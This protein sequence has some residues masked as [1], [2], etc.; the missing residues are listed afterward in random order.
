MHV[1][2]I[3]T[4]TSLSIRWTSGD[5]LWTVAKR[6]NLGNRILESAEIECSAEVGAEIDQAHAVIIAERMDAVFV[7]PE[8]FERAKVSYDH[9]DDGSPVWIGDEI[10][11]RIWIVRAPEPGDRKK[12]TTM[13]LGYST[14]N[15]NQLVYDE[16]I[17]ISY[18][19]W[20]CPACGASF[21]GGGKAMHEKGCS[22]TGYDGLEYHFGPKQVEQVK[23]FAA[24][25]HPDQD[26][27][28]LSYTV[29][30]AQFPQLA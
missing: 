18:G 10:D 7:R 21:Y 24:K 28:G 1:E 14:Y 29:L 19:L 9:T 12:G 16:A 15:D 26:W 30:Q 20:K 22:R 17:T 25:W 11:G 13:K 3:R 4:R 27:Y 2:V 23:E 5:D 8:D 6:F